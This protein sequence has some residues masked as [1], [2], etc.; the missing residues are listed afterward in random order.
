MTADE[1]ILAERFAYAG[2]ILS[3]AELTELPMKEIITRLQIKGGQD[4]VNVNVPSGGELSFM[5][6][7][8]NIPDGTEQYRIDPVGSDPAQ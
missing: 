6:V 2:N 5:M 8:D 4:Q 7:F 1:K 3:E